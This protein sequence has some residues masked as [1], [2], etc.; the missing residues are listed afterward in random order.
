MK[1]HGSRSGGAEN[2]AKV[3]RIAHVSVRSTPQ[4]TIEGIKEIPAKPQSESFRDL[5]VFSQA[6]IFIQVS[7]GSD[8]RQDA[9]VAEAEGPRCGK[10][11][12]V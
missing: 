11:A 8:G 2:S 6:E 10:G 12:E 7:A 9:G 5:E 1:L 4:M 3:G